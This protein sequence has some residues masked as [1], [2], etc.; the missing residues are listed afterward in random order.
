VL[1]RSAKI[2]EGLLEFASQ[3]R[4]PINSAEDTNSDTVDANHKATAILAD[5][6]SIA[7]ARSD[8]GLFLQSLAALAFCF[9]LL[10]TRGLDGLCVISHRAIESR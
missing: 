2:T 1:P 5:V 7:G 4:P 9:Q 3:P 10:S 6:W 8:L